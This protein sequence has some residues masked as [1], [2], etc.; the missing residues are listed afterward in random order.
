MSQNTTRELLLKMRERYRRGCEGAEQVH[1]RGVRNRVPRLR[2]SL[3]V[4]VVGGGAAKIAR[5]CACASADSP[6]SRSVSFCARAF[7]GEELIVEKRLSAR[8][9]GGYFRAVDSDGLLCFRKS[10]RFREQSSLNSSE[11]CSREARISSG[12][13]LRS[14]VI[15]PFGLTWNVIACIANLIVGVF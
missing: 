2:D 11:N 6:A 14:P 1:R 13:R 12:V 7:P 5:A 8:D 3:P 10:K 4:R 15:S 9:D